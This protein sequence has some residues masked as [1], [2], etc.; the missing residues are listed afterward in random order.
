MFDDPI[1]RTRSISVDILRAILAIWVLFAHLIPQANALIGGYL[2]LDRAR[3]F[4]VE[5]FN[6]NGETHP[7][8]LGF[9]V[10]SGYCIHR[11]GLRFSN[12]D[13]KSY[14]IRRLFRIYP[15]Y[16]VASLIGWMIYRISLAEHRA[17]VVR[18]MAIDE[19]SLKCLLLKLTCLSAWFQRAWFITRQGN[20]PLMTVAVEIW[21]YII[22]AVVFILSL[23]TGRSRTA[24][25]ALG[26]IWVVASLYVYKFLGMP[27]MGQWWE[28]G[29][30][31]GFLP[32]WWIGALCINE[33]LASFISRWFIPLILLWIVLTCLLAF[34]YSSWFFIIQ[35]RKIIFALVLGL[36]IRH[37]DRPG[38]TPLVGLGFLGTA[39]YSI[40]ALHFPL[41][42]AFLL[43]GLSLWPTAVL[44]IGIGIVFFICVERPLTRFGRRIA[45]GAKSVS[46]LPAEGASLSS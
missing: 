35:A 19:P 27:F 33:G 42:G 13:V 45:E 38:A 39:G 30:V 36:F 44:I 6:S 18:L 4:L 20:D 40:Y 1:I 5:I 26:A 29:S 25:A 3:V 8:V 28:E 23:H 24:L 17:Q 43:S 11:N 9:I 2:R 22:Y 14:A 34:G 7:A 46:R 21:L 16:I 31:L 15:T 32:Y 37:I 41:I 12:P 10:L